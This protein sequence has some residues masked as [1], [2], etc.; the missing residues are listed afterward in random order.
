MDTY[1]G[2]DAQETGSEEMRW[3][4]NEAMDSREL[5]AMPSRASPTAYAVPLL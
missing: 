4:I 5:R 1:T 2:A 3:A